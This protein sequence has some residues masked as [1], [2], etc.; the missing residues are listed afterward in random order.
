MYKSK[1]RH[2]IKH[3]L[4]TDTCLESSNKRQNSEDKCAAFQS[5]ILCTMLTTQAIFSVQFYAIKYS[6]IFLLK[7]VLYVILFGF[8]I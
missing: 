3:L 1:V 5:N 8:T 7:Y 4:K 6:E 2:T